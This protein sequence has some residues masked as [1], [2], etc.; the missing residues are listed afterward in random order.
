LFNVIAPAAPILIPARNRRLPIPRRP[1]NS[2]LDLVIEVSGV[3]AATMRRAN[4]VGNH[5][6]GKTTAEI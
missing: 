1:T 3:V 2:L 4:A 6:R 5:N